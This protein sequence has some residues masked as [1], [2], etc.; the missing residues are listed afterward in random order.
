[1][2]PDNKNQEPLSSSEQVD[3]KLPKDNNQ[4]QASYWHRFRSWYST[5]KKL[6]IPITIVLILSVLIA[7]PS[8][9]Y[10]GASL[11]IKKDYSVLVIDSETK[12][13]VSGALVSID[14]HSAQT[15]GNGTAN[16]KQISVGPH[17]LIISKK[18][19]SN[20]RAIV[21]VPILN[22]KQAPALALDATGRQVKITVKNL[23]NKQTL[24]NVDIKV[25]GTTAKTDNNGQALVVLPVG[26][27]TQQAKL[28][29]IGYNDS[30]ATV[31]VSDSAIAENNLTLTPTGKVYFLSKR[32]GKLNLMKS[33]LDGSNAEVVIAGTGNEQDYGTAI[34]PST[35]WKYVALLSK[36]EAADPTPQL[37]I[38]STADDKLLSVDSGNASFTLRGWSGNKLIYYVSRNNVKSWQSGK[39]KLKSYD[40]ST[41]KTVVLDQNSATGDSSASAYE[42]YALVTIYGNSVL[43]AKNWTEVYYDSSAGLLNTK[44]NTVTIIGSDGLKRKVVSSYSAND[45]VQYTQHSPNSIYIWQQ[46]G[47]SD[48]FFDYSFGYISPKS[49]SLT[50]DQFY[51]DY[52]VYFPSP[53]GSQ[54]FWAESRDGKNALFTGDYA[55]LNGSQIASSSK[56]DPYGW[57]T[58]QY[59]LL[60]KGNSELYIMGNKGGSATRIT[61]YQPTTYST[62]Y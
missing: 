25:A 17:T 40:A 24:A 35:D 38:L 60:T 15:N 14:S 19:Y 50:S 8:S 54:T 30:E 29:L 52:P 49:I 43:F 45:N 53:S 37:Y 34:L 28:K 20:R 27:P 4:P 18:Y 59:L 33:D 10:K 31:K 39:D 23:V 57:Y 51:R 16:L 41:G 9:R 3:T 55:G 2:E 44:N 11:I 47:T 12:A 32:S 56:Y 42:Y 7:V 36:R 58:D 21:T 22:Q 6:S 48:K 62:G 5:H 1:M 46:V 26:I 61:D 13:P